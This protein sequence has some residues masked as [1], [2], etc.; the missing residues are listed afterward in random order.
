MRPVPPVSSASSASCRGDEAL[1][2]V[3]ARVEVAVVDPREMDG[4]EDRLGGLGQSL[5]RIPHLEDPELVL[6]QEFMRGC[7]S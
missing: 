6:L 7:S 5:F 1:E 4:D 3:E 2:L